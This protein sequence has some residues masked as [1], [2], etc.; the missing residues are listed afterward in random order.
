MNKSVGG[1]AARTDNPC[2]LDFAIVNVPCYRSVHVQGHGISH[3]GVHNLVWD[4][5]VRKSSY[6]CLQHNTTT[7]SMLMSFIRQKL[8]IRDDCISLSFGMPRSTCRATV[9]VSMTTLRYRQHLFDLPISLCDPLC[10][11]SSTPEELLYLQSTYC[12]IAAPL[13]LRDK[14]YAIR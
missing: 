2:L 5:Y 11:A 14:R 6:I 12:Y 10:F 13:I 8:D 4:R 9:D 3:Y 7:D 1:D